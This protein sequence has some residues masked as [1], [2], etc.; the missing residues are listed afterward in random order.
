MTT[1][2][3][4]QQTA[5]S[6]R[7]TFSRLRFHRTSISEDLTYIKGLYEA[8]S[9]KNTVASG[10]LSYPLDSADEKNERRG[11]EIEFRYVF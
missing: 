6:L 1:L 4:L 9:I 8:L 5:Q 10:A 2:A 3:L 11:M 7:W